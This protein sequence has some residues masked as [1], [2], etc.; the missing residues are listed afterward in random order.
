M[1]KCEVIEPRYTERAEAD[2]FYVTA[3]SNA[4]T[5]GK[6]VQ[7]PS[8]SESVASTRGITCVPGRPDVF[9]KW[10]ATLSS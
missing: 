4:Q 7:V 9:Q 10:Y 5:I 8:G 6:D 3:G 1:R 2:V